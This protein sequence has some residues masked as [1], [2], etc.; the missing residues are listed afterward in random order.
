M[1]LILP[2]FILL[3]TASAHAKVEIQTYKKSYSWNNSWNDFIASELDL[4]S[5]LMIMS[6][7][8]D[9]DDLKELGCPG[10]NNV[11]DNDLKK[12]FWVVFFSALTRA[13]VLLM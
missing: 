8:I 9:N 5:E 13:R 7:K 11:T 4:Q 10:Y 12:D 6:G 3:A 1:K 2:L